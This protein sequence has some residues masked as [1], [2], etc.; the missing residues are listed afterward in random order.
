MEIEVLEI[1]GNV[2]RMM[3]KIRRKGGSGNEK[4][5]PYVYVEDYLDVLREYYMKMT[6]SEQH[7]PITSVETNKPISSVETNKQSSVETNKQSSVETNQQSSVE[8]SNKTTSF[9]TEER[10]PIKKGIVKITVPREIDF[11]RL[12]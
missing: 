1:E 5:K 6:K 3:A 12:M 11:R 2:E 8:T 4:T 10:E 7:K 9:L